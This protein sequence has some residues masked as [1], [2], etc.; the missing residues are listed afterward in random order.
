MNF[1]NGFDL[2]SPFDSTV[3]AKKGRSQFELRIGPFV[4]GELTV[5]SFE[6]REA[7]NQPFVYDV[8]F[9]SKLPMVE[10]QLGILE[11]PASLSIRTPGPHEPRVIQGVAVDFEAIGASD[12]ELSAKG[13]R[14]MTRIV[15]RLSDLAGESKRRLFRG[16]SAV[17]IVR[18]VLEENRIKPEVELRADEYPPIPFEYQKNETDL[19]FVNRVLATAGIFYYFRHASGLLD[20]VLPGAGEAAAD[21]GAVAGMAAALGGAAA[22]VAGA[23]SDAEATLGLTSMLVLADR[24]DSTE[25]L[26]DTSLD[27]ASKLGDPLSGALG[28][29][30]GALTDAATSALGSFGGA[31]AGAV[32]DAV[33]IATGQSDSLVFDG[34]GQAASTDAER[35]FSFRLR[36]EVRPRRVKLRSWNLSD[37][38][39]FTATKTAAPLKPNLSLNLSGALALNGGGASIG[40]G[41][42]F[43]FDADALPVGGREGTI[44]EYQR[45]TSLQN[46]SQAKAFN[47]AERALA[48]ERSDGTTARGETDCRRLAPGYRFTL[49]AH[50]IAELNREYLVTE[51][52]LQAFSPDHLPD[53]RAHDFRCTFRCVPSTIDPRPKKPAPPTYSAEPAIVVGPEHGKV[54]C[55]RLSRILVR[56]RWAESHGTSEGDEGVCWVRWLER[57]GGNGYGTQ[58]IPRVGTEVL[59]DFHEGGEPF[60][61]GHFCSQENAP[62]FPLP[63]DATKVGL[64]TRTIPNGGESEISIDDNPD[65]ER[66]LVRASG[67]FVTEV[68]RDTRAQLDGKYQ[69]SVTAER[70]EETGGD[71]L[72]TFARDAITGVAGNLR[73]EVGKDRIEIVLGA[74]TSYVAG[75]V[76]RVIAGASATTIH[77]DRRESFHADSLE[78]HHGHRAVV[79][80]SA[81][82]DQKASSAVHVEGAARM[83]AQGMIEAISL[84]GFTL[85]CGDSHI[86][87]GKDSVT[88]TS[89][90]ILLVGKSV[91]VA[92][93]DTTS[94]T[95]K[96]ATV[97]A[98][99]SVVISGANKATVSGQSA[100]VALDS[101]AT[102]QGSKVN[103]G[104]GGGGPASQTQAVPPKK[105]SKLKLSDPDGK[106]LANQLVV[107]RKGGEG[108][109]ERMAVL[110]A[111]GELTVE[112]DDPFEVFFP[113]ETDAKSQ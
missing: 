70:R 55:D 11:L 73:E 61:A 56:F 86:A 8:V 31:I 100:S 52:H 25:Q 45:D 6:G 21:V 87:I 12:E 97:A 74:A 112:G 67:D 98:S 42:A 99:D 14:F 9:S 72:F 68:A 66:V 65:V 94:I 5:V 105:V 38:T 90:T 41:G 84:E 43:D 75:D 4:G 78:R 46:V 32:G 83:Y 24:A 95:A 77:G 17:Q 92:A 111:S 58:T 49:R 51:T 93:S 35:V 16:K 79:V 107:L 34:N 3:G 28:V 39:A 88:I 101:N 103:L 62:A 59:V 106:P 22:A 96:T 54:Y 81:T 110:D 37:A 80:A 113:D 69:L 13:R 48:Q 109:E 40:I 104:S 102:V 30:T 18:A 2:K 53:A 71:A 1:S 20:Q 76:S 36:K 63:E 19:A 108:G 91:Q 47:A 60:A 85:T 64:K 82:A 89:P 23:V 33:A 50:P 10:L 26:G 29:A 44:F 57:W 7:L 15:P 27:L